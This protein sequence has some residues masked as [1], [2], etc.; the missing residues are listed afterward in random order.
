MVSSV[1]FLTTPAVSLL[2]ANLLLGEAITADLLAGSAL[3][4][5]GVAC[6]A[7]PRRRAHDPARDG[8]RRRGRRWCCCTGCSARRAISASVQ[9]R[10]GAALPRDRAGPAQPR[11]QPA[12]A[13]RWATRPWRRTCWR[14]CAGRGA[15][16]AA[17][18]GHSMGGKVAMMAALAAPGA[19]ARLAGG[20][21]RAGPLPARLS[22][23]CRGDGGDPAAA[24]PDPRRG[25]RR[26]GAAGARRGCAP[27]CC[28]TCASA[29][30]PRWRIDLAAITA[31]L[32]VLEDW[33]DRQGGALSRPRPV[34]RRRRLRLH[35]AGASPGHPRRFSRRPLRHA[36]ARRALGARRQ[37]SRIC[38]GSRGVPTGEW[39]A[40]GRDCRARLTV[41]SGVDTRPPKVRTHRRRA[42]SVVT[43]KAGTYA[44]V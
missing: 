34:H 18:V 36:E 4:M 22:R 30:A 20:G 25:R 23:A 33:P 26:T 16:P 13:R 31:A 2:L 8:G 6:A 44:T 1:G 42:R 3:I 9:R 21:H 10:L 12:C 28:R 35:P 41:V 29:R 39:Q 37:S 17:L 40:A 38:R 11:R 19:V 5:A 7:W 15:L 14:R 43:A 24:R 32:P 27:S